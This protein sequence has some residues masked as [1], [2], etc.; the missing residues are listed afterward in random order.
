MDGF[1]FYWFS[2]MVV[3]AIYFFDD[4]KKRRFTYV[5]IVLL[6]IISSSLIVPFFS[7]E[8]RGTIFVMALLAFLFLKQ[9]QKSHLIYY[10]FISTI[11]AGIYLGIHYFVFFEPVWLYV[12]PLIMIS[13]LSFIATIILVKRTIF[14]LGV[15]INGIVQGELILML[16]LLHNDHA[17][18]D[19]LII[20]DYG[21]L[22]ITSITLL[23]TIVWEG[24]ERSALNLSN[25]WQQ[26]KHLI[27]SKQKKLNA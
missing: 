24:I 10:N 16:L 8:T 19:Y 11:L 13:F 27:H 18:L 14:R 6:F 22:D 15:I 12:S 7:F 17:Y 21:F 23:F 2:W 5:A 20:G 1:W 25:R 3:I 9:S 4:N 26:N